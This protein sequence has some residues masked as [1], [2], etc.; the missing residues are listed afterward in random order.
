MARLGTELYVDVRLTADG[1]VVAEC[2]GSTAG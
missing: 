1:E 2:G